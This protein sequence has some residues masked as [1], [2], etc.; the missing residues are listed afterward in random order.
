M[1][2]YEQMKLSMSRL[3][4]WFT[5]LTDWGVLTPMAGMII[6]GIGLDIA[7]LQYLNHVELQGEPSWLAA[8]I[9]VRPPWPLFA[10]LL[11]A[12]AVFLNWYWRKTSKKLEL[13][14]LVPLRSELER[15]IDDFKKKSN[16]LEEQKKQLEQQKNHLDAQKNQL[17]MQESDLKVLG[18][19]TTKELMEKMHSEV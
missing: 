13:T 7:L 14:A 3:K 19:I 4:N 12:P 18:R 11:T 10:A 2:F 6:L 8:S 16:Q 15:Q 5:N 1:N 9:A 17:E